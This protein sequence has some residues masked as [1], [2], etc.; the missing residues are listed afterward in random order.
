MQE[1]LNPN[2]SSVELGPVKSEWAL[3]NE[4]KAIEIQ[5]ERN[6]KKSRSREQQQIFKDYLDKQ[7]QSKKEVLN[8]KK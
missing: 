5:Q 4:Y 3:M 1:S 8:R 6:A 2:K 7:V